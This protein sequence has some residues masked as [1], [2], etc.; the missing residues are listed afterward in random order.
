[1]DI[2]RDN[3]IIKVKNLLEIMEL[4]DYCHRQ[5]MVLYIGLKVKDPQVASECITINSYMDYQSGRILYTHHY[6]TMEDKYLK[7]LHQGNP[8]LPSLDIKFIVAM[9]E[10]ELDRVVSIDL[11]MEMK[12][13]SIEI[14][15]YY[16]ISENSWMYKAK[17]ILEQYGDQIDQSPTG[18]GRI[19]LSEGQMEM[20]K[21]R[22]N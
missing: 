6:L 14:A 20:L 18:S 1:M 7:D 10:K 15:K 22:Y 8:L 3:V 12:E 19:L 2:L 9:I 4:A 16:V 21:K 5:G 17:P 11:S 13:N